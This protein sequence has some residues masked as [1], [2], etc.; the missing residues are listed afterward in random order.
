MVIWVTARREKY[1]YAYCVCGGEVESATRTLT[2]SNWNV[3]CGIIIIIITA[4]QRVSWID[5]I[6]KSPPTIVFSVYCAVCIRG[7]EDCCCWEALFIICLFREFRLWLPSVLSLPSSNFHIY[8]CWFIG[9]RLAQ[10]A[11][12][13][14]KKFVHGHRN[15]GEN[16]WFRTEITWFNVET[17]LSMH[18]KTSEM[19]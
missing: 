6:D 7:R 10:H 14:G 11:S 5:F 16:V 15:H 13:T 1:T 18:I 8:L 17:V 12:S 2:R 4:P 9:V 3:G 19:G